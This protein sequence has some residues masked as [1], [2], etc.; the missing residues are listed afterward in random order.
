MSNYI[1]G[2]VLFHSRHLRNIPHK[3]SFFQTNVGAPQGEC[4]RAIEFT[5]YLT[6]TLNKQNTIK[7]VT[8]DHNYHTRKPETI[9]KELKDHN[10][11]L[12]AKN[13]RY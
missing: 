1:F 2:N 5:Y 6:N 12:P 3:A 7:H 13:G 10:Y 11:N 4:L 8:H 9:H